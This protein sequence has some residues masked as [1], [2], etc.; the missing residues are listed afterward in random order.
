MVQGRDQ[1]QLVPQRST[2]RLQLLEPPRWPAKVRVVQPF[3]YHRTPVP[4]GYALFGRHNA[5]GV[6]VPPE[7]HR[8]PRF[9]VSR[10]TVEA[11]VETCN[12]GPSELK[13]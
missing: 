2:L 9:S 5:G 4:R 10:V 13:D 6:P 12:R 3:L 11:V 8:S 1:P 7:V